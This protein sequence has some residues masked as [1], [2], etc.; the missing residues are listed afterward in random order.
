MASGSPPKPAGEEDAVVSC[1][2]LLG[3]NVSPEGLTCEFS[4]CALK[5]VPAF[6]DSEAG[7]VTCRAPCNE[8]FYA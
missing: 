6:Y 4:C 5:T 7:V 2:L 3:E 1:P 8:V